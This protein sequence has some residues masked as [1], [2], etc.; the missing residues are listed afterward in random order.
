VKAIYDKNVLDESDVDYLM[1]DY[2][3]NGF[4]VTFDEIK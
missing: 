3:A 1:K 4:D 2:T